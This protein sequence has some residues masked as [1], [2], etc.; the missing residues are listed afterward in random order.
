MEDLRS[1]KGDLSKVIAKINQ[2]SRDRFI[3]TFEKVHENF[4]RIFR[5]LC[6]RGE[7]KLILMEEGDLLEAGIEIIARPL[8]SASR[9]SA[10]S[11]AARRP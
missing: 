5:T 4:K 8:G 1:A 7:D 6:C 11:R 3:Q 2:E 9:A 10:C